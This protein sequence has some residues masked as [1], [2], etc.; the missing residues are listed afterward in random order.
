MPFTFYPRASAVGSSLQQAPAVKPK[1]TLN[2]TAKEFT[3]N[4]TAK[5]FKPSF[6][7]AAVLTLPEPHA[8]GKMFGGSGR[9][10][11]W[12]FSFDINISQREC[13]A[14]SKVRKLDPDNLFP[15]SLL[16]MSSTR[17][18]PKAPF[19][20][21][22][23]APPVTFSCRACQLLGWLVFLA[24]LASPGA[25][26]SSEHHAGTAAEE[27]AAA[28]QPRL[29]SERRS[30]DAARLCSSICW[31]VV[32]AARFAVVSQCRCTYTCF[33]TGC[34]SFLGRFSRTPLSYLTFLF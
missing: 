34:T 17:D 8:V 4:P 15:W 3:F 16:E 28:R 24:L 7:P 2:A 31:S 29:Q 14:T 27:A 9:P 32:A 25:V 21:F 23:Q 30:F 6:L 20:P 1:S 26:L 33:F 5:E 10:M 22:T 18:M 13:R 12:F 19:E 11:G